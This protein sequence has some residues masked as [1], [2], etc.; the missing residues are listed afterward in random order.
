MKTLL[1]SIALATAGIAAATSLPVAAQQMFS[2]GYLF[3]KAVREKDGETVM[4]ALNTPGSTI[5]NSRDVSTGETALHIVVKRRD[6]QWISFLVGKGANPNV[7]DKGGVYPLQLAAQLGFKEGV[8][9]L[10]AA[11]ARVDVSN[12]AGETPL[13]F[14]VH[15]RDHDMMRT[16]LTGGA[17]PDRTDNSGRSA[18]DYAALQGSTGGTLAVIEDA[19]RDKGS[20][21]AETY[22]PSF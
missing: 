10:M 14:A 21:G 22:G 9:A 2:D 16:L 1:R 11:Q 13:I 20:A 3:L 6:A 19:E 15:R 4:A 17:D 8:E 7:A 5:I 12:D 18:R